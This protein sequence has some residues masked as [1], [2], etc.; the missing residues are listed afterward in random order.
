MR[1]KRRKKGKEEGEEENRNKKLIYIYNEFEWPH[2]FISLLSYP[3]LFFLASSV[4][5]FVV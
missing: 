4:C 1:E 2:L 5:Q 3:F